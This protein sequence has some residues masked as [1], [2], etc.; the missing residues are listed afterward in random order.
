VSTWPPGPP[1]LPPRPP[2][3]APPPGTPWR[4]EPKPPTAPSI[5]PGWSVTIDAGP[6]WLGERMAAQR[7][8]ML[9]GVVDRE[10]A[11]RA[12]AT[13]ALCDAT[14]DDPVLLHLI[15]VSAEL[16]VALMLVDAL[17]LVGAPVHASTL[18]L[19][20]G[21][22]VAILAVADRRIAGRNAS[23]QLREPP[24]PRGFA[25]REL[26]TH[27]EHHRRRLRRLQERIAAACGQ[28]VEAVAADM[29][30]GRLLDVDAARVYGLLDADG[31]AG[32]SR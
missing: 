4:P 22:A 6:D 13:L 21:A 20:D 7:V 18:G 19:L 8:V 24:P 12:V 29:R 27:A 1:P 11:N 15:D 26:E 16:D 14:G 9:S 28:P 3:P 5:V 30:A 23:V 17:D 2:F 31:R 32:V 25:A 10:T